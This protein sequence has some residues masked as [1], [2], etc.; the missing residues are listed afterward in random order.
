MVDFY[1]NNQGYLIFE[2]IT[3]RVEPGIKMQDFE[4]YQLKSVAHQ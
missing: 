3:K 1:Y 2:K 4:F